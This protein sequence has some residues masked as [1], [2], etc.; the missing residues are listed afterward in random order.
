M[1]VVTK[2]ASGKPTSTR[3]RVGENER[4]TVRKSERERVSEGVG[5]R[6]HRVRYVRIKREGDLRTD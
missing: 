4:K 6:V 5:D 3:Q 2:T 1:K